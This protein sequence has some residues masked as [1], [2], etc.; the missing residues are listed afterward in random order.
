MREYYTLEGDTLWKIIYDYYGALNADLLRQ[1]YETN[2][3]I[4]DHPEPFEQG[5]KILLPE[6]SIS[7]VLTINTIRLTT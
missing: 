5:V 2:Q 3:N 4:G 1:I 7:D 6:I